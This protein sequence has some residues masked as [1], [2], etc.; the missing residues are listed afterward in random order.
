MSSRSGLFATSEGS[1]PE[2]F[3]P[4]EWALLVGTAT[5]WG[6]S[7]LWIELGLRSLEPGVISAARVLLGL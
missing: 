6:S 3:G 5:I 7:Y 1:R 4:V 2:A